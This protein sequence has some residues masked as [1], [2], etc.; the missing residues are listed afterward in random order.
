MTDEIVKVCVRIPRS[1]TDELLQLAEGWRRGNQPTEARAQGWD[2]KAIHRVAAGKFG[3]LLQMFEHH[4][5]PE[6]GSDMMRQVQ[7]RVRERYGSVDKFVAD[8]D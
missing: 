4:G 5:W 6:R 1:R 7:R 8:H 2:A 3:G